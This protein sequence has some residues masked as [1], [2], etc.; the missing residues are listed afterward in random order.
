M[1]LGFSP[2]VGAIAIAE[3]FTRY[4]GKFFILDNRSVSRFI[5]II[6]VLSSY[7]IFL[8]VIVHLDNS[9]LS[10][11]IGASNT[12]GR[13][14]CLTVLNFLVLDKVFS[15]AVFDQA[16]ENEVLLILPLDNL[17]ITGGATC[18]VNRHAVS[19]FISG[20]RII[21]LRCAGRDCI[22]LTVKRGCFNGHLLPISCVLS[23]SVLLR[24][25]NADETG[26]ILISDFVHPQIAVCVRS[27]NRNV[28]STV[29]RQQL[30][31]ASARQCSGNINLT[32]V[33][34]NCFR[35]QFLGCG[36]IVNLNSIV[37]STGCCIINCSGICAYAILVIGHNILV[38]KCSLVTRIVPIQIAD[39]VVG[40]IIQRNLE[41][42][43]A[44]LYQA[45]QVNIQAA[46]IN[47]I[48]CND[49]AGL[50]N[51]VISD[52]I[53][54]CISKS[55]IVL[56]LNQ[57]VLIRLIAA[58]IAQPINSSIAINSLIGNIALNLF[59]NSITELVLG[60]RVTADK[61]QALAVLRYR[62]LVSLQL[63]VAGADIGIAVYVDIVIAVLD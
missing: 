2:C 58:D 18:P 38:G 42:L 36:I 22:T 61:Q 39:F 12:G 14:L 55:K 33:R 46:D 63:D 5:R 6:I 16:P 48:A 44:A 28:G 21:N 49:T 47:V 20:I 17:L 34:L 11:R 10:Q 3:D 8:G 57:S 26:D 53:N 52:L 9:T 25:L 43:V 60:Y 35:Q 59:G 40:F 23:Q 7:T 30:A 27:I 4:T 13:H 62:A 32:A 19:R 51:A 1:H 45:V 56:M 37:I 15:S 24:I 29:H 41:F 31:A 50:V 54:L